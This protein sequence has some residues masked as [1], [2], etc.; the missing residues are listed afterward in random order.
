MPLLG[1]ND[2]VLELPLPT[3]PPVARQIGR[4]LYEHLGL[5]ATAVSRIQAE[6]AIVDG[7]AGWG[8]RT[9]L[10]KVN[11]NVKTSI[12]GTQGSILHVS[13]QSG[14]PGSGG[15]P[16]AGLM[17]RSVGMNPTALYRAAEN[18]RRYLLKNGETAVLQDGDGVVGAGQVVFTA[19]QVESI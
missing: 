9:A 3:D 7:G 17:L 12:D 4:F 1:P 19:V 16:S 5:P 6:A 15:N 14:T 8:W 2:Q 18:H 13:N 10:S 11:F